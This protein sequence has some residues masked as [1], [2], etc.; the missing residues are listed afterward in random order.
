MATD[1]CRIDQMAHVIMEGLQ[2]YAVFAY[3]QTAHRIF[4]PLDLNQ[5]SPLY[6]A[7]CNYKGLTILHTF[8][9]TFFFNYINKKNHPTA[10][11]TDTLC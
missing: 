3:E 2:E 7:L 4:Y 8:L 11:R 5:V 6:I 10:G 9:R 1:R